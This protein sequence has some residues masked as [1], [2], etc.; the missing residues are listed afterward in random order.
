M[1]GQAR[2]LRSQAARFRPPVLVACVRIRHGRASSRPCFQDQ[3]LVA[4][5]GYGLAELLGRQWGGEQEECRQQ[6]Q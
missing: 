2:D 4:I 3:D 5:Y 6:D 1:A